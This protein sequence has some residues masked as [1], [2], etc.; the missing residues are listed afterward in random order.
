MKFKRTLLEKI[1]TKKLGECLWRA[2]S[3][4]SWQTVINHAFINTKANK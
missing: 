1:S 2:F 3:I 4:F